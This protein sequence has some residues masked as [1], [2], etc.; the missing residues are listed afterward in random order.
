MERGGISFLKDLRS[1]FFIWSFFKKEKPDIVHLITIKPY[2]YGGII[3]RLTKVPCLVSAISGLGTLFISTNLKSR[4]LRLFL[5]PIFKFAFNHLNQKI[6]FH[7][8]EDVN[9]LQNWGALN[10]VK[11]KILKGSGVK[12]E[13]FKNF[14]EQ[15]GTPVV[16]FASRL[17]REKGIFEFVYAAKL[18][19]SKDIKARFCIAGNLDINNPSGLNKDDLKKITED[20]EVEFLGFQEDIPTLF[21]KSHIICLPSYREGFPKTL[22]EAAAAGRSVVTSDVPGCRDAIIPKKTGLLVPVKDYKKLADAIEWLIENPTERIAMGR[23]GRKFAE[24]E[25]G[26]EKIVQH[27]LDIYEELL[28]INNKL[29]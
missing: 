27:H 5:K 1:V 4:L 10:P 17:L 16:C 7:N 12:L 13:N 22:I 6:I 15:E 29:D 20:G 18:L 2:L 21:S 23:E 25:F 8:K 28:A 11:V 26:I 3:S 19:K 14:Q 9:L 24:K